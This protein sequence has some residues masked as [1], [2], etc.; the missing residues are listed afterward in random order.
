MF[1]DK[2]TLLR[3]N[4]YNEYKGFSRLDTPEIQ[5][6]A[7]LIEIPDPARGNDEIEYTQELNE[8]PYIVITPKSPEQLARQAQEKTNRESLAYLAATDWMVLRSIDEPGKPVSSGV[9]AA[10]KAARE[11]I[12]PVLP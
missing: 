8:P 9:R 11:A 6:R 3:V 12:V 2:E 10:R 7:G 5:E 4:I 1:I